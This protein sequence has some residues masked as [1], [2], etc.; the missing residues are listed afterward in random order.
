M[1]H[2]PETLNAVLA[3][4]HNRLAA[5]AADRNNPLHTPVVGTSDGDLRVMVL[6]ELHGDL[7][8]LRFHTDARSPKVVVIAQDNRA[9]LLAYDPA[10]RVQL[11]L[12]GRARIET[13]GQIADAAWDNANAFARRCYLIEPGPG[14]VL[15]QPGSGL[16]QAVAGHLPSEAQLEPARANFAVL[17]FEPMALDW[18]Y[19]AHTG[20]RRAQFMRG[21]A[22]EDWQ[23]VWVVP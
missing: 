13:S 7:A 2:V 1:D 9:S 17:L 14:A 16:P 18:L 3:D 12:R 11:R 15:D 8:L 19:L 23:G 22:G 20:H 5:A 4:C 10:A 6:R 21:A